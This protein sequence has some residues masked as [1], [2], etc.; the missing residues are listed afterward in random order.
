MTVC[1][2]RADRAAAV[3][4]LADGM[5]GSAP[6]APGTWDLLVNTTPIGT[7]PRQDESPVPAGAL[8]GGRTVYDLVY[9]P[10]RTR[11]L[12]EAARVGCETIGGLDMLVAQA[13]HQFSWW[14]GA[15]PP[16]GLF[17]DVASATLRE[18]TRGEENPA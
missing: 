17:H 10:R 13:H 11:L 8:A 7:A 14:F 15:G 1:G 3:A 9:N 6:P 5:T 4:A 2:R 16:A 18:S 12:E